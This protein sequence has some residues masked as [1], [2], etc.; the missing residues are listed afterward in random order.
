MSNFSFLF[1]NTLSL[2]PNKEDQVEN[3]R[4]WQRF[5]FCK[6]IGKTNLVNAKACLLN[7]TW[8]TSSDSCFTTQS[9]PIIQS[10]LSSAAWV[11]PCSINNKPT[12]MPCSCLLSPIVG[13]SGSL[14][15]GPEGAGDTRHRWQGGEGCGTRAAG[16]GV[17]QQLPVAH[18][19]QG[20]GGTAH[21]WVRTCK[22]SCF[23]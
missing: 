14:L 21:R 2:R 23:G 12:C 1:F 11:L 4:V 17:G 20:E 18:W 9:G 10:T 16:Q 6:G 13:S 3:P 19:T 15:S 22:F 5:I 7:E 8:K